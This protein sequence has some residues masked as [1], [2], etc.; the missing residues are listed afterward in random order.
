M[1][2]GVVRQPEFDLVQLRHYDVRVTV[3]IVLERY[4]SI[5]SHPRLE[6]REEDGGCRC[7]VTRTW[8]IT[9]KADIPYFA[10]TDETR[11]TGNVK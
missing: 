11:K 1:F 7:L 5:R 4:Y 3:T 8:K 9:S 10:T 2:R 6:E